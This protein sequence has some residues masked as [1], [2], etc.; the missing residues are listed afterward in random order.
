MLR[1]PSPSP[2]LL[3]GNGLRGIWK[4]EKAENVENL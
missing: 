4:E 2:W 1:T 3:A